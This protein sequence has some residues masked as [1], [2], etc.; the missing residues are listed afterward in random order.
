M[1]AIGQPLAVDGQ[2]FNLGCSIGVANYPDD[3]A[4]PDTLV[5]LADLAMYAAKQQGPDRVRYYSPELNERVQQRLQLERALRG[6]LERA[7]FEVQYQV[8][9]DLASGRLAGIEALLCWRHP[10]LG[11]VARE[12]FVTLAEETGLMVP[13]GAWFLRQACGQARAWRDAGLGEIRIGLDLG[14]RQLNDGALLA[15]VEQVL[16]DTGLPAHCLQL[17]LAEGAVMGDV[18]QAL[19]ALR[20]LRALGVRLAIDHF[21]TGYSRLAYLRRFPI[22]ALKIDGS[23]V[24]AI[25]PG[26]GDA[27]IL[28]AIISM[29][30]S[31]GIRVIA[32][33]VDSEDQCEFLSRNMCDEVQGALLAP[34]LAADAMGALL[35][36]GVLVPEHLRRLHK[37]Q[38]TLLLV[39]D[40][41]NILAALKRQMRGAGCRI[42]TA[43]GGRE[44]LALLATEEVDVIV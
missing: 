24:R 20:G 25:S 27:A 6:A 13:I 29:A 5:E 42:L 3:S 43:P 10:E 35:A 21:G 11:L 12:R 31:L 32:E 7:E 38:R 1:A 8:Q 26:A 34:P 44:G 36:A 4:D 16:A 33:G 28:D 30:H 14:A 18:A 19:E 40:E 37:R 2:Q 23:F 9:A 17:E 15:T 41:P 39:D 22:D